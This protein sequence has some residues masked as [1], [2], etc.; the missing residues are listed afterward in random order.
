MGLDKIIEKYIINESVWH[1][2]YILSDGTFGGATC[3]G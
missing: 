2:S 3:V 1:V